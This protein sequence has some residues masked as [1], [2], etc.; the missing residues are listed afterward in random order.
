[1][2]WL[3]TLVLAIIQGL[4]EF[5]PVSSSAHLILPAQLLDWEDQG[6]AFDVAV[7]LGTLIAVLWYYRKMLL[8]MVQGAYQGMAQKQMNEDLR[9]GLLLVWATLPAVIIG[10]LGKDF[11][12]EYTRDITLIATTTLVFGVLMGVAQ[13]RGN[14]TIELLKV[15]L[16]LATLVGLAQ[17]LALIP[18]TSRSGI[19]I[20]AALLL[21]FR[22]EAAA[23]FSFLLSIPIILGALVLMSFE[24]ATEEQLF[25]HIQLLVACIV[26]GVVGYFSIAA[27]VGFISRFGVMS[28]V[29]YRVA[30]ALV[31]FAFFV[32]WQQ[33]MA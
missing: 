3:Q 5:L 1:M 12:Q 16:G 9:L 11:I 23:N 33:L 31:L 26:S 10:F 6:L 32:P 29:Y 24:L 19:T 28:F 25:T 18:G 30:L 2:D 22:R 14:N 15:G 13:R 7:H 21:G 27:F 17:A 20:T 4:T 8:A